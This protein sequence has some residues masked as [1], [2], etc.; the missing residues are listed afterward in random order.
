[1]TP[2]LVLCLLKV[3]VNYI[4]LLNYNQF[5]NSFIKGAVVAVVNDILFTNNRF[6]DRNVRD[7]MEVIELSVTGL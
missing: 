1:M 6:F 7:L 5:E 3:V 4:S 2:C